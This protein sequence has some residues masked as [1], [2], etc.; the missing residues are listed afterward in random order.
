MTVMRL[1]YV[2]LRVGDLEAAGDGVP[3]LMAATT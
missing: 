1:G 2:H 3:A